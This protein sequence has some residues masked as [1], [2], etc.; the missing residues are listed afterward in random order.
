M[1]GIQ[2]LGYTI[3][4]V[5]YLL[6]KLQ[7]LFYKKYVY[8]IQMNTVSLK[9]KMWEEQF[10]Q[11]ANKLYGYN[12]YHAVMKSFKL[13]ICVYVI[14]SYLTF[15]YLFSIYH[16]IGKLIAI[17]YIRLRSEDDRSRREYFGIH[18]QNEMRKVHIILA[19]E[20]TQLLYFSFILL[21]EIS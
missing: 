7:I 8:S 19:S 4:W 2:F 15:S 6:W 21:Y 17:V 12:T 20:K 10:R 9:I 16:E 1:H 11:N 14:S 3:K 5:K 13:K 18:I